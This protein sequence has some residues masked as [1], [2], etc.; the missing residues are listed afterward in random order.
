[1]SIIPIRTVGNVKKWL[2]ITYPRKNSKVF[3]KSGRSPTLV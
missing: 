3:C 2:K 1:M